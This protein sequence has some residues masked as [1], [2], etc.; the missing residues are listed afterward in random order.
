MGLPDRSGAPGTVQWTAMVH[1]MVSHAGETSDRLR[2]LE[3][4]PNVSE[5]LTA[6]WVECLPGKP[7]NPL[8]QRSDRNPAEAMTELPY[9]TGLH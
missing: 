4:G 9:V 1:A 8:Q 2:V 3:Q 6:Y 5:L 7:P